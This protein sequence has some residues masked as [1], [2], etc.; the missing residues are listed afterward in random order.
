MKLKLKEDI[1]HTI[2]MDYDHGHYSI[3]LNYKVDGVENY[4]VLPLCTNNL[5]YLT[6]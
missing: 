3:I 4:V 6:K 5:K 1:L 2:F